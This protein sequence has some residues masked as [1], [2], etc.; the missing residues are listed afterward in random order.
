MDPRECEYQRV[1]A[2]IDLDAVLYN[3]ENMKG[4]LQNNTQMVAVI[5]ADGYG[6]GSVPIAKCLEEKEYLF[7]FAVATVEEAHIL[8]LSNISKPIIVLDYTFPYSYEMMGLEDIRP[9]VFRDD[10]VE[11][12]SQAALKIGKK[13]KVHIKVDTGMSRVGI[14]PDD[15]GMQFVK[16]LSETPGIEIE[17][18]LTHFSRADEIDKK[19]A[20]GQLDIFTSFIERIEKELSLTIP[21]KHCSNSAAILE[22]QEANMNMVRAGIAMYGLFP[23][24]EIKRDSVLLR[25]ALSLCS[26][27]IHIKT[28]YAGQ[29]VSYSGIFTA[30]QDMK[31]ATIPVGYGD[32]YPR[33]LSNKGYILIH[34]Q[35]AP[36]LG[37]IC[38]DQFMVDITNIPEAQEG[39]KVTLIGKDGNASLSAEV[40][41]ERSGRFNYELV[42]DL[43]KRIPRVYIQNGEIVSTKDY[44]SDV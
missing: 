31:I 19:Y 30:K 23:S 20:R 1:Y 5:K 2:Q 16:R 37:R 28:L 11:K 15:S 36:I 6:H 33:S 7:G 44:Y 38:M 25:P 9:I 40:V 4:N 29:S 22:L 35:K 43:G 34:G 32:G 14:M 27:I 26:H 13:I 42:C 21:I 41:G 39:D 10:M 17:G 8:R 3:A 24:H 18:I 12:M